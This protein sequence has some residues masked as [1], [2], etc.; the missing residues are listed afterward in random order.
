MSQQSSIIEL[1]KIIRK[2]ITNKT[3][4]TNKTNTI[5]NSNKKN[6]KM[7]S[8]LKNNK[9]DLPKSK[10]IFEKPIKKK[11]EEFNNNELNITNISKISYKSPITKNE[12]V[13]KPQ[14]TISLCKAQEKDSK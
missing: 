3:N 12:M 4:K 9:F 7:F 1:S 11:S 10:L 8:I 6:E 2:T 14:I 5:L 13:G